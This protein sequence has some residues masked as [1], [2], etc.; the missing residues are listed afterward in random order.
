VFLSVL[1]S[2]L[3]LPAHGQSIPDLTESQTLGVDESKFFYLG[4][5]GMKGWMYWSSLTTE[6]RQILVTDIR[7][8]T[9]ADGVLEYHDVI[10]GTNGVLFTNDARAAFVDAVS[11]AEATGNNGELYLTVFR[12]STSQTNTLMVQLDEMG[13]YSATTPYNCPKVDAILTNFCEYV[14]NNGPVGGPSEKPSVWA[15]MASGAPKYVNWATNWVMSQSW[16]TKT[17]RTV[18]RDTGLKTWYTGYQLVTLGQ[19]YLL[20][21]NAAALPAIEDLAH[22]IAQGSDW[23]GIWGHTMAWPSRNGGQLHGTLPGYGALNQAGLVALYG[24]A[25][26]QKCGVSDP[27]VDAAVTKAA[28]FFRSHV[29]LGTINYGY[30]PP[31][32]G[33]ADSNG[34]NGIAAHLFRC[35]GEPETAKWFA[36]LTST[37]KWR[38]WGHTGNEFNH[39]W[40]PMAAGVGGPALANFVQADRSVQGPHHRVS[41][42][43]RR[44]PE[45]NFQSQGQ[46]GRGSGRSN[47]HATGGY[48]IQFAAPSAEIEITGAGY[49][50]NLY[51]LTDAE[52]DQVRFSTRYEADYAGLAALGTST[53]VSNLWNFSPRIA[54]WAAQALADRVG[55]DPALV[56]NLVDIVEDGGEEDSARGAALRALSS[57]NILVKATTD[58]WYDPASN[59]YVL[60]WR[61]SQYGTKDVATWTNIMQAIIA[62]DPDVGF[63]MLTA[64]QLSQSIYSMDTNQLDSLDLYYDAAAAILAPGSGGGWWVNSQQVYQWDP[65]I[66]ARY[67]D[68]ILRV[69]E[70]YAMEYDARKILATPPLGEGLYSWMVRCG[71]YVAF[72]PNLETSSSWQGYGEHL[73]TYSNY[74]QRL[75]GNGYHA[76]RYRGREG[77]FLDFIAKNSKPP[78][79]WFR[80]LIATNLVNTYTNPAT[81]LADLRHEMTVGEDDD[82][83]HAVCLDR[84][85]S[86]P[87]NTDPFVD[88]TNSLGFTTPIPQSH[89]RLYAG[90]VE[91]GVADTNSNARWLTA[92]SEAETAGNDTLVGGIL[93]VLGGRSVTQTLVAATNYLSHDNQYLNIA[94][95]DVFESVGT[96]DDLLLLFNEYM[97][98]CYDAAEAIFD[99]D[100]KLYAFWDAIT[101]IVGR[102]SPVPGSLANQLAASFNAHTSNSTDLTGIPRVP[103]PRAEPIPVLSPGSS[104]R[105]VYGQYDIGPL[106]V[107]GLFPGTDCEEALRV[108]PGFFDSGD[109]WYG[110]GYGY[111]AGETSLRRFSIP[112]IVAIQNGAKT[113]LWDDRAA[114]IYMFNELIQGRVAA[115]NQL[116]VLEHSYKGGSLQ[117]GHGLFYDMYQYEMNYRRGVEETDGKHFFYMK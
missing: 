55:S 75:K 74:V 22:F 59:S 26:A 43:L 17:N 47:G 45:G 78:V 29:D 111:C 85:V 73:L 6:A 52:M 71:E 72:G 112:E 1:L 97:T 10:L 44:Q 19:Y 87:D 38:D 15:M 28:H 11:D 32:S 114:M 14:Y 110:R 24:M 113:N 98:N 105:E 91:L 60:I 7:T 33:V 94:A 56:S 79:Q 83:Y 70:T 9:P 103:S 99:T 96:T 51:W 64:N 2:A 104:Q 48:A 41:T 109:N 107:L 13:T 35:L 34:R 16:A 108:I 18:Y 49:D 53:L 80:D 92:L 25:L 77:Y 117:E 23:K 90:A 61:A 50:T 116:G 40:G 21:T 106:A 36:M 101:N 37:Y 69:A 84:I 30:N 4:P 95:L 58:T 54:M 66:L 82:L 81:Q 86:H 42:T 39:C 102:E 88:I 20:T 62:L 100:Y 67:A 93:H 46:E 65:S 68:S 76:N 27:E 12:P 8:G 31:V 115:S 57:S 3:A 89:W 63:E 5:T